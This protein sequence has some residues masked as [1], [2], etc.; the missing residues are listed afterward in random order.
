[1]VSKYVMHSVAEH[2]SRTR[3]RLHDKGQRTGV[4]G[5]AEEVDDDYGQYERSGLVCC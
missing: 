4:D 2:D 5:S 1:V 3:W